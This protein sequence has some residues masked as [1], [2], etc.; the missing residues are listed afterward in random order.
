HL[1]VATTHNYLLFFTNLGKVYWHKVYGLPELPPTSKGRAIVNLLNL[2]EG[3]TI[4]DCRAIKNFDEPDH[5]LVLATK[6][7]LV[8]KTALS[9]F[10]RPLKGGLIAIK[11]R[12]GDELIDVTVVGPGDELIMSTASGNAIRFRHTDARAM[13]RAASGVRGV[14]LRK[15]DHVVGMVI[16][17]PDRTL[18][19]A[20]ANGYGKRTPIGPNG[21]VEAEQ[22]PL[23][24][25]NLVDQTG[26]EISESAISDT[27]VSDS[28]T[29]DSAISDS[30]ITDENL[31]DT[32]DISDA[33]TD[34]GDDINSSL[35]YRTKHRGGLGL[36]DIKTTKRNGPVIGISRVFDTDEVMMITAKGQIQRV[37]VSDIRVMGRN[38]QGVR[39]M[40]LDADDTL[41]AVKRIP[42]DDSPDHHSSEN[43][44]DAESNEIQSAVEIVT[45]SVAEQINVEENME[46]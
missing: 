6:N 40:N 21:A 22:A 3:E 28:A 18:L 25:E 33:E 12:E 7:G 34:A 42:P 29:S 43:S 36:K 44:E 1:F 9:A 14:R 39:L 32:V 41:V 19:T 45:N 17:S 46:E 13:G 15:G 5:Y 26:E 20:C 30:A 24:D 37:A 16:A 38:T 31:D 4:A 2:S 8:K 10:G 27:I 11:L 23:D 35:C